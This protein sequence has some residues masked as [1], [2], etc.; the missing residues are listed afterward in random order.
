M[1]SFIFRHRQKR[2]HIIA[3]LE[4][5]RDANQKKTLT[6]P[7]LDPHANDKQRL[8]QLDP[9]VVGN[10]SHTT[11]SSKEFTADKFAPPNRQQPA[12]ASDQRTYT[13]QQQDAPPP[14]PSKENRAPYYKQDDDTTFQMQ[15][16]LKSSR[17]RM[18]VPYENDARFSPTHAQYHNEPEHLDM[19]SMQQSQPRVVVRSIRDDS[20]FPS[21]YQQQTQY[22]D[23]SP[24]FVSI[25]VQI[26][27]SASHQRFVPPPYHSDPY[28]PQV[29]S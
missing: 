2:D 12:N 13:R 17:E 22:Q 3:E 14:I 20:N 27:H 15:R 21:Y 6:I 23:S 8:L 7:N 1:R 10:V 18:H 28:Y 16:P 25:P 5:K 24:T 29:N 9:T 11:G 4:K 19:V 26:E